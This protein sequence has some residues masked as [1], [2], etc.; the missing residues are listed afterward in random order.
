MIRTAIT[1]SLVPQARQGPFVFHGDLAGSITKAAELGY[2]AVEIFPPAA[3]ALDA[4]DLQRM[5]IDAGVKVAAVG[6]GAGFV[7][8]KLTLTDPDAAARQR[9]VDFV[10][11]IIDIAGPLRAPAIVGSMQGRH[12]EG[13][14]PGAL[15]RL[16]DTLAT[17]G[18]HARGHGVPLLYEP[19]NR[20]ETNIFN[21]QPEAADFL[22][23]RGVQNVKVLCDLFHMNIEE[24]DVP[25]ALRAVGP[26]RLGHVHFVDSNRLAPG[27]GHTDFAPIARAL[28][29]MGYQGYAS[30]ECFPMP[31]AQTAAR[32][33][34]EA[35]RRIF[36]V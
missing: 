13:D 35:Y 17:L 9:A 29:E 33:T 27:M 36:H 2:D 19:L 10:K 30:A 18:V 14:R 3:D 28:K 1:I 8:H 4:P 12:A 31:D 24:A 7:V 15:D 25:A 21:R 22:R 6:S 23:S 26:R 32:R 5:T 11:E 16:A 20:Y 34:I